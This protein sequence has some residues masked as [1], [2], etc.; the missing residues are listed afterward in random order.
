MKLFRYCYE[1]LRR[2]GIKKLLYDLNY[3][4]LERVFSYCQIQGMTLTLGSIDPAYLNSNNGYEYRFLTEAELR[5]FARDPSNQIESKFLED[6][7]E[8]ENKCYGILDQGK[9]AG[10][11]WYSNNKTKI[12]DELVLCLTSRGS[13]C[14]VD[15][16]NHPI[17][18]GDC[19]Q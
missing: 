17:G 4:F 13:I 15:I 8:K 2:F 11:G 10:Y 12:N 3:K 7:L 16:P 1:N 18:A 6:A 5:K 9:L 14:L 19:T